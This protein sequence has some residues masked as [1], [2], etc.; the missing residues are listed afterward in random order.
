MIGEP[1]DLP[2]LA[3]S[4][5]NLVEFGRDDGGESA[6]YVIPAGGVKEGLAGKIVVLERTRRNTNNP[7]EIF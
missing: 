5:G 7:S 3:D 1:T 4:C 6:D 2:Q